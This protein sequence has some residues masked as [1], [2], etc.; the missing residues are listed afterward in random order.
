MN[1]A[2]AAAALRLTKRCRVLHR[3]S[4][5]LADVLC[6]ISILLANEIYLHARPA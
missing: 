3:S 2:D 1:A 4:A 6:G 5:M